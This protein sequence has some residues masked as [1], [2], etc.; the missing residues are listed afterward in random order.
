[1]AVGVHGSGGWALVVTGALSCATQLPPLPG[2]YKIGDKVYCTGYSQTLSKG[3][4]VL[5]GQQGEVV[6]PCLTGINKEQGVAVQFPGN[7]GRIGWS[8]TAVRAAPRPISSVCPP[9]SGRVCRRFLRGETVCTSVSRRVWVRAHA[10]GL[11]GVHESE[12][13]VLTSVVHM[14]AQ[15]SREPPP[16]L[17]GGVVLGEKGYFTGPSQTLPD[18]GRVLH[19]QQGEVVGPA[20]GSLTGKGLAMQ[21]PG[22]KSG[23]NCSL[24]QVRAPLPH[25][26]C[27]A[28]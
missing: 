21:F 3:D 2:S 25:P 6:G 14:C 15:L 16:P 5:H 18:G 8:L 7:K 13:C 4:R 12:A 11:M 22:N 28:S 10:A 23:V 20:T 9:C 19:G 17:P 26:C 1:M 24:A 27:A